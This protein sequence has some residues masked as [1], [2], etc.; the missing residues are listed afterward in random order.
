M[1][2]VCMQHMHAHLSQ[3]IGFIEIDPCFD[4]IKFWLLIDLTCM[5]IY[6]DSL[7]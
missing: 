6:T 7:L 2:Q 3:Y 4:Y 5:V 1:L